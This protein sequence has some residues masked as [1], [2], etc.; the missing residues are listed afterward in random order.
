MGELL[1]EREIEQVEQLLH[2]FGRRRTARALPLVPELAARSSA[3]ASAV[4]E[5]LDRHRLVIGELRGRD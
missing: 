4:E 5:E 2:G 3:R 1:D